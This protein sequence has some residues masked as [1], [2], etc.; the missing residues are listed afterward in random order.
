MGKTAA[1]PNDD[2]DGG[3]RSEGILKTGGPGFEPGSAGPKPASLSKLAY[4][5]RA[6]RSRRCL[7][8]NEGGG[9]EKGIEK[10]GFEEFR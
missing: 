4:T 9:R 8:R 3:N 5:P 6:H 7:R 10:I 1:L 2:L